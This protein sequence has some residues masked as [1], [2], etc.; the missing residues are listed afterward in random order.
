M[1]EARVAVLQHRQPDQKCQYTV[2]HYS[3]KVE[4]ELVDDGLRH[5]ADT[6]K[7][8]VYEGGWIFC[9]MQPWQTG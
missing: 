6:F 7:G 2:F 4:G 1:L 8:K 5:V 3:T 9:S